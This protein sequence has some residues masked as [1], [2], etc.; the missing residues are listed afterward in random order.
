MPTGKTI[1]FTEKLTEGVVNV[2]EEVNILA[3]L[4]NNMRFLQTKMK[5]LSSKMP[6]LQGQE[7]AQARKQYSDLEQ[8]YFDKKNSYLDAITKLLETINTV[9]SNELF[10]EYTA[11]DTYTVTEDFINKLEKAINNHQTYFERANDDKLLAMTKNS[12]SS[13]IR[14]IINDPLNMVAA[15]SPVDMDAPQEAASRSTMGSAEREYNQM[16]PSTKWHMREQN[17]VGKTAIGITAV[18]EKVLFALQYYF[19]EIAQIDTS[20]EEGRKKSLRA[21]FDKRIPLLEGTNGEKLDIIR[22]LVANVYLAEE[23]EVWKE[24]I[25]E[26]LSK[27][28][29]GLNSGVIDQEQFDIQSE[30]LMMQLSVMSDSALINSSLLS[31]ATD[32]AKELILSKINA[33]PDMLKIYTYCILSIFSVRLLTASYIRTEKR[34]FLHFREMMKSEEHI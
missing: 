22:N 30:L 17:M 31:A 9:E 2:K 4:D 19:N 1:Y 25:Q 27:L 8:E 3:E 10:F 18:G 20:T 34:C 29:E 21:F 14:R 24:K 33:N 26:N 23:N 16:V 15:Y 5:E 7:L 6:S 28:Q 13:K 11:G 12:V 32:N